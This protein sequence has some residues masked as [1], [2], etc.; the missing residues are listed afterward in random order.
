MSKRKQ[1]R[2]G[3]RMVTL[4]KVAVIVIALVTGDGVGV[5]RVRAWD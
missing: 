1:M 5:P 4:I 3:F 2:V